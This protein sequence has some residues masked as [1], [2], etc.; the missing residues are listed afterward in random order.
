ML[1]QEKRRAA[2]AEADLKEAGLEIKRHMS[3]ILGRTSPIQLPATSGGILVGGITIPSSG[4][5]QTS[6]RPGS[7]VRS[8]R[9]YRDEVGGGEGVSLLGVGERKQVG[10]QESVSTRAALKAG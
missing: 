6:S 3:P 1:K 9:R 4:S 5:S 2:V 7:S 8:G 10:E